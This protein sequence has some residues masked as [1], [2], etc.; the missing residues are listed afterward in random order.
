MK[1]KG[2]GI[3][4]MTDAELDQIKQRCEYLIRGRWI[5]SCAWFVNHATLDIPK[6]LYEIQYL[7]AVVK[8]QVEAVEQQWRN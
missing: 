8:K 7:R 4:K 5:D 6:L 3:G 2:K 1:T